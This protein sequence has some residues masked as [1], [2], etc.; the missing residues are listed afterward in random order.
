MAG[1]ARPTAGQEVQQAEAVEVSA[2]TG[3]ADR[4]GEVVGD[5]VVDRRFVRCVETSGGV[6]RQGCRASGWS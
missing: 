4:D 3:V 1:A 5:A 2:G 6:E